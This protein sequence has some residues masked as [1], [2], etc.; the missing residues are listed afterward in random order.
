M[1]ERNTRITRQSEHL[2]NSILMDEASTPD[3]HNSQNKKKGIRESRLPFGSAG[4]LVSWRHVSPRHTRTR[5]QPVLDA[6]G[7]PSVLSSLATR[8]ASAHT[9]TRLRSQAGVTQSSTDESVLKHE[10]AHATLS[11]A[12][13]LSSA[14]RPPLSFATPC[15]R[16]PPPFWACSTSLRQS[17][18]DTPPSLVTVTGGFPH[19][20]KNLGGYS[21]G[22]IQ[23]NG[24]RSS[25]S[26]SLGVF[27]RETPADLA[28]QH[29]L[30]GSSARETSPRLHPSHGE[31]RH[32]VL[33]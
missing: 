13:P 28:P 5:S 29:C 4:S 27:W 31:C 6:A 23:N 11:A 19:P 26:F 25:S 17:G 8:S 1:Q 32:T 3:T 7:S 10:Q 22:G 20:A 9:F 2:N 12:R 21:F 16:A 14:Y 24:K 33:V 15:P 18:A 30:R